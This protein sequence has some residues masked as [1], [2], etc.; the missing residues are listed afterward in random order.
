MNTDLAAQRA[1]DRMGESGFDALTETDQTLATAWL[2]EATVENNG[3]RHF[4][5]SKRGN[6]AFYAP[7]ALR[8]IGAAQLAA[9]AT[10][11]NA[12]FG[13]DGPPRDRKARQAMV[14]AFDEPTRRILGSLEERY[15]RCAEDVDELLEAFLNLREGGKPREKLNAGKRRNRSRSLVSRSR[16]RG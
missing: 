4:F 10:E 9:I 12:V 13:P 2:V 1:L 15:Y 11:A 6:V 14:R 3:F 5:A 16:P 8:M 7:V